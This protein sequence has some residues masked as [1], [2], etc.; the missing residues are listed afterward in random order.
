MAISHHQFPA[1]ENP[2]DNGP[3]IRKE[4]MTILGSLDTKSFLPWI[5]RHADKLC[6]E[7][8][9]SHADQARIELI[10]AGPIELIDAMEMGCSLGPINVWVEDIQRA[11]AVDDT[12]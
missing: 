3:A 9:I 5:G 2:W 7:Q 12:V 11:E 4:R 1:P 6:L 10:L 8:R